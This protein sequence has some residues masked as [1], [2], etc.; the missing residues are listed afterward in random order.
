MSQKFKLIP[1]FSF[2]SGKTYYDYLLD[3]QILTDELLTHSLLTRQDIAKSTDMIVYGMDALGVLFA[4]G[5]AIIIEAINIQN[6][7]LENIKENIEQ[8]NESL[9]SPLITQ[10]KEYRNIG[11]ERFKNRLWVEAK[12]SFEKALKLDET[13]P[14]SNY[15]IGI[16]C[17]EGTDDEINLHQ[18]NQSCLYFSKA[19]KYFNAFIDKDTEFEDLRNKSVY[20]NALSLIAKASLERKDGISEAYYI[21][22]FEKGIETVSRLISYTPESPSPKYLKT[23]FLILLQKELEADN[24]FDLLVK[25]FPQFIDIAFSDGDF[26]KYSDIGKRVLDKQEKWFRNLLSDMITQYFEMHNDLLNWNK[27]IPDEITKFNH[28]LGYTNREMALKKIDEVSFYDLLNMDNNLYSSILYNIQALKPIVEELSNDK[29]CLMERYTSKLDILTET[30]ENINWDFID[31]NTLTK[32]HGMDQ[33]KKFKNVNIEHSTQKNAHLMIN[34]IEEET[35]KLSTIKDTTNRRKDIFIKLVDSLNNLDWNWVD[36]IDFDKFK[37]FLREDKST[38]HE[39]KI[40]VF[41]KIIILDM[42]KIESYKCDENKMNDFLDN[43]L[44]M[45][46]KSVKIDREFRL[47]LIIKKNRKDHIGSNIRKLT[48]FIAFEVALIFGFLKAKDSGLSIFLGILSLLGIGLYVPS[49]IYDIRSMKYD[50]LLP[51]NPYSYLERKLS[52][53]RLS[54]MF[55]NKLLNDLKSV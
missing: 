34:L 29:R 36:E 37:E 54:K 23:K 19:E 20:L 2:L 32:E 51:I 22:N 53:M 6:N 48:F 42:A 55:R 47:A 28:K 41:G 49:I 52:K 45:K 14:L 43:I 40:V 12:N 11:M 26:F 50:L 4:Q 7:K 8:I 30:L 5:T 15:Y 27:A 33:L 18:P 39:D 3:T 31:Q 25:G 44:Y 21:K 24:E 1:R 10:A 38:D 46:E 9:K 13:D 35:E 16:I 17:L